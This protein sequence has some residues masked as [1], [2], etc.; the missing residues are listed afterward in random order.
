MLANQ[1]NIYDMSSISLVCVPCFSGA[2]WDL[3]HFRTSHAQT[4]KLPDSAATL[5]AATDFL[6]YQVRKLA[7]Y[8]LI[9]DSYGAVVALNLALRKPTG[10]KALVISGGFASNTL[11]KWKVMAGAFSKYLPTWLYKTASLRFHASQLVSV[12]DKSAEVPLGLEDF[13]QLFVKNTSKIAY[14]N[15]VASLGSY[16]ITKKLKD[17]AV[18][19]LI[20]TPSDD[21]LIGEEHSLLLRQ[22]IPNSR[23][24]ILENSGHMFRFT[25]PT[26]YFGEIEGFVSE[27]VK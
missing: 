4:M 18:P 15:R 12:F 24:V 7:A 20:L 13:R 21:R 23:E 2:E 8:V 27:A 11:P 22:G 10:L 19:T 26:R 16:D 9:G 6:E 14:A 3:S 17:I 5:E 1:G 25:H